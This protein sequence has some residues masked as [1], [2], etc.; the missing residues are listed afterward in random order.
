MESTGLFLRERQV[1]T[2]MTVALCLE[3]KETPEEDEQGPLVLQAL[4]GGVPKRR[5][6]YPFPGGIK[7]IKGESGRPV[8][9]LASPVEGF[10]PNVRFMPL[11]VFSPSEA[12]PNTEFVVFVEGERLRYPP[13]SHKYVEY[14]YV[15][16]NREGRLFSNHPYRYDYWSREYALP[17]NAVLVPISKIGGF[18]R[19]RWW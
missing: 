1:Y 17:E 16:T 2:G 11:Q 12:P 6:F 9:I 7:A 14:V 18:E 8:A 10:E 5:L 4:M 15:A 13:D 3:G 19:A